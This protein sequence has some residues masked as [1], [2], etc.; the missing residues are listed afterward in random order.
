MLNNG[1]SNVH[2]RT[3]SMCSEG[4]PAELC[5]QLAHKI[6]HAAVS[7]RTDLLRSACKTTLARTS[8]PRKAHLPCERVSSDNPCKALFTP[9]ASTTQNLACLGG[10][11]S[12]RRVRYRMP[13]A[14]TRGALIRRALETV[15]SKIPGLESRCLRAL[16]SD[17]DDAGPTTQDLAA[18]RTSLTTLLPDAGPTPTWNDRFPTPVD[19]VLL[20][21]LRSW[22][23]DPDDQPEKWLQSGAPAGLVTMPL[24]RGIFPEMDHF[25]ANDPSDLNVDAELFTNYV[26][27]DQDEIAWNEVIDLHSRGLLETLNSI[28]EVQN[29]LGEKPVLSI[30][31]VLTEVIG[32]KLKKRV[33]VDSHRS[34]VSSSTTKPERLVLP[35]VMDTV[36]DFMI[37]RQSA[38]HFGKHTDFVVL[39]FT[40]AFF[41]IPLAWEE[42]RFF[43]HPL[44][45][46]VLCVQSLRPWR[47]CLTLD[48]GTDC[49]SHL[50]VDTIHVL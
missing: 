49:C 8:R 35:R 10:L 17:T 33:I 46:L 7:R 18:A 42:R 22:I 29:Y 15:L 19:H 36:D 12:C 28:E 5:K 14:C 43:C 48:L 21:S 3:E 39:D 6:W 40:S 16:G 20:A 23:S 1:E 37:Q 32:D 44:A 25:P 24:A 27:V 47:C 38:T 30:V 4:Y 41:I 26:G 2:D 50:K 11:R 9:R 31:G 13:E 34:G 45:W